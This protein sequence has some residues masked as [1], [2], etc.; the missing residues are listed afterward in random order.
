MNA[1]Q[2]SARHFKLHFKSPFGIA[3]GTRNFTDTIYVKATFMDIEG[4]GEAALPPY[5]NYDAE[6]LVKDYHSYFPSQMD[7]SE[8]IRIAL[9]K[10]NQSDVNLPKPLRSATDIALHD[11][12]GKLTGRTVRGIF[13]IGERSRVQCSYTL[14]ISSVEVM[15]EKLSEAGDFR[16]FKLKLGD[17]FD[18]A[19]I[20]AFLSASDAAFC[21]DANQ[22]WE[23]TTESI[24]WINW[25]KDRGCLF[26][27]QPMPV[28]KAGE[29][30]HLF[31]ASSL[32]VILDESLQGLNELE[33][34]KGVCHGINVKLVKCGGIEPAVN[35]VR[36]A[37]KLGL[38]VLVGCMSESSCGAMAA[39]QLSAWADWVDLDGPML[40]GNDPFSGANYRDGSLVLSQQAGTGAVLKD[41]DLFSN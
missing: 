22:A 29:F 27:E 35:L 28:S 36:Q 4:Y 38:K 33:E 6:T 41:K 18:K 11:L 37:N 1:L 30:E 3:H 20:E 31:R 15:K 13:G 12:F 32:P 34:L 7:G 26:V 16:L 21:V 40:I 5:L 19:R 9:L 25:L 14:G 24:E 23:T 8:A 10:L 39:A 17:Q 2:L